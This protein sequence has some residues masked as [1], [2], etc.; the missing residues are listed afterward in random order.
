MELAELASKEQDPVKLLAL[1]KEINE[2]LAKKQD[3]LNL[4]HDNG[5]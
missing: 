3:R 1:V 5:K 4:E 2:L